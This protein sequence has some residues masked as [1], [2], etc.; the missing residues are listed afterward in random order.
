MA[1]RDVGIGDI[2]GLEPGALEKAADGA[3]LLVDRLLN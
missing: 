3:G 1:K 2:S